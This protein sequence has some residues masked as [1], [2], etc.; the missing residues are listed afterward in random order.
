M[1]P[2]RTA[3]RWFRPLSRSRSFTRS[4]LL[5]RACSLTRLCSLARWRPFTRL[6]FVSR[7]LVPSLL[8][9]A[10]AAPLARGVETPTYPIESARTRSLQISSIFLADGREESFVFPQRMG[11][12]S[13]LAAFMIANGP[14]LAILG[15][16]RWRFGWATRSGFGSTDQSLLL[17]R[18]SDRT[19]IGIAF[20]GSVR[21]QHQDN[22]TAKRV[23][24]VWQWH[25]A[26]GFGRSGP[27][28]DLDVAGGVE[29][30]SYR[31]DTLTSED[32]SE[33]LTRGRTQ[34]DE[35][36]PFLQVRYTHLLS[37]G[38][39]MLAGGFF[40]QHRKHVF[41]D[42]TSSEPI[43][44]DVEGYGHYW[45]AG[46][47][48]EKETSRSSLA[49]VQ[50]SYQDDREF[51]T[52]G[53]YQGATGAVEV[54]RST[55]LSASIERELTRRLRGRVS[56]GRVYQF[57]EDEGS[58]VYDSRWSS[59]DTFAWGLAYA[60]RWIR[61]EGQLQYDLGLD[62]PFGSIDVAIRP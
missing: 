9:V 62:T 51:G 15:G 25:A 13:E 61:L 57:F 46:F 36:R 17:A 11:E 8:L 10:L 7:S 42:R 49:R 34:E 24:E 60:H 32:D 56:I 45:Y 21:G 20:G 40:D 52:D 29:M 50:L 53:S 28:S 12:Q 54:T 19:R 44:S 55:M 35:P 41:E 58:S 27:S 2:L 47:M 6:L 43:L 59:E 31:D 18:A 1:N 33:E 4:R 39:W 5:T 23:S 3:F 14:T 48:V 16:E 22:Q 30:S 37:A 38:R 26:A